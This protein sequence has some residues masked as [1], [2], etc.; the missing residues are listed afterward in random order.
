MPIIIK[1]ETRDEL[2]SSEMGSQTANAIIASV[3]FS[4][5]FKVLLAS[6]LGMI[7]NTLDYF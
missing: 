2:R 7:W 5:I 3:G 1:N 4:L 6:S